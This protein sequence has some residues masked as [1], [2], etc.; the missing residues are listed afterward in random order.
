[1][2]TNKKYVGGWN[3]MGERYDCTPRNCQRMVE[4]GRLPEPVYIGDSRTPLW[5]IELLD[6]HD[7]KMIRRRGRPA[8]AKSKPDSAEKQEA[9]T[10]NE[11]A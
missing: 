11:A 9:A 2:T 10:S 1:M 7:R 5:E 6:E 8:K 3:A 4:D